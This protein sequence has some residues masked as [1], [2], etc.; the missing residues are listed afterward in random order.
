MVFDEARSS[1]ANAKTT[2]V[3][4]SND[5]V[6]S[7]NKCQKMHET[8][9]EQPQPCLKTRMTSEHAQGTVGA[10]EGRN[11]NPALVGRRP[12]RVEMTRNSTSLRKQA[13]R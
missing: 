3:Q 13:I 1:V 2:L 9:T 6:Q 8:W 5:Y 12:K 4:I 11:T 10:H 7:K